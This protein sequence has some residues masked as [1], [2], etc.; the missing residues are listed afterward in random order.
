MSS[1]GMP[2]IAA[3]LH[4]WS[5]GQGSCLRTGRKAKAASAWILAYVSCMRLIFSKPRPQCQINFC[6][7]FHNKKSPKSHWLLG[8]KL[9]SFGEIDGN[10][11]NIVIAAEV[12]VFLAIRI[13]GFLMARIFINAFES[14][15]Q[16][17][18]DQFL[19]GSASAGI[20]LRR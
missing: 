7:L 1:P 11:R 20:F 4:T 9:Q 14:A 16:I 5:Y 12:R 6:G 10:G 18:L 17:D 8:E 13:L 2:T 3:C 19:H 15:F